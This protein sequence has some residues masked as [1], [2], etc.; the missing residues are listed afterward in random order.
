MFIINRLSLMAIL[1]VWRIICKWSFIVVALKHRKK[2]VFCSEIHFTL[3]YSLVILIF[4]INKILWSYW[5]IILYI[6][7]I[8]LWNWSNILLNIFFFTGFSNSL[9]NIILSSWL[10]L[11]KIYFSCFSLIFFFFSIFK[12]KLTQIRLGIVITQ[13]F[14]DFLVSTIV[15]TFWANPRTANSLL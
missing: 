3:N 14:R 12:I 1:L 13:S 8:S 5:C 11:E 9:K 15:F 4:F 6:I 10:N 7:K 2:L